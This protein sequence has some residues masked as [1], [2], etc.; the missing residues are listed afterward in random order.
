M[1]SPEMK[2]Q[3]REIFGF[4]LAFG[5]VQLMA[6]LAYYAYSRAG[7]PAG[8]LR[9]LAGTAA[10]CA[11]ASLN[12][13]FM[14]LGIERA[15]EKGEKRAQASM[16]SGYMLRLAAMAVYVFAVIKLPSVFNL[17]AAVIPLVFPRAAIAIINLKKV[18]GGK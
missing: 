10:G 1:L 9:A 18:G 4:V 7:L 14:A 11:A 13:L 17:W 5:F 3:L 6:F 8:F 15:V 12:L 2:K 16:A